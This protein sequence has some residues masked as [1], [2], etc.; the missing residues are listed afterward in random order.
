M[1]SRKL[2]KKTTKPRPTRQM[3]EKRHRQMVKKKKKNS[4]L[5]ELSEQV[6]QLNWKL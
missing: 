6:V 2:K 3:T 4:Y 1:D 5:K